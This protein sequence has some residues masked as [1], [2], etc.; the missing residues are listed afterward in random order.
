MGDG[1]NIRQASSRV[2]VEYAKSIEQSEQ[3]KL[4]IYM[5]LCDKG[6]KHGFLRDDIKKQ[7]LELLNRIDLERRTE[8][9]SEEELS[10]LENDMSRTSDLL[11]SRD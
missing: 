11:V 1:L 6:V 7:T 2:Q 5:V 8:Y 4:I 9:L 3:E 10:K